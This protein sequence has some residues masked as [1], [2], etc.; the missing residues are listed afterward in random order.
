MNCYNSNDAVISYLRTI[1]QNDFSQL[2]PLHVSIKYHDNIMDKNYWRE[3]I[4]FEISVSIGNQECT[5]HYN[6]DFWY[7]I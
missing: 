5:Y 1:S 4:E 2:T 6:D 3:S 7:Y